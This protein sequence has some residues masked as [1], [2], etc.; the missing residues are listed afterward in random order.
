MKAVVPGTFF[1]DEAGRRLYVGTDPSG[2]QVEASTL[3]QGL[4]IQGTGTVV[5]GIGARRY[6]NTFWMGGAISA[7][8]DNIVLENVVSSQ[9]ATIGVNG[10]GKKMR[11]NRITISESGALGLALNKADYL[12]LSNSSIQANNHEL[13]KIAPV[14]GGAKITT[15]KGVTVSGS[16][17]AQNKTAGLWFDEAAYDMTIVGNTFSDN[18]GSGLELEWSSKA[19][20]ANNYF[21]R[22]AQAGLLIMDANTISVWNNTFSGNKT[23]S[24][25]LYQDTGRG[26]NPVIWLPVRDVSLKNNV[27]SY[28]TGSCPYL[29]YDTEEKETGKSMRATS[30]A[31]AYYRASSTSPANLVCWANSSAGLASFKTLTAFRTAT[32][33]DLRST[34]NEGTP[35]LTSTFQLTPA[36]LT[37]TASVALPI[38]DAVASVIGVAAN[39]RKLGAVTPMVN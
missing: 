13:F 26:S 29:V 34:L 23:Y 37:S 4:V 32:G 27:L 19:L 30:E 25:R 11:F 36:A 31:N 10:W 6:G 18:G 28:G 5:R 15:S 7:Q 22:N 38:P 35:I 8:V 3:Q 20:V 14:S 33:N 21:I 17:F 2:K 12:T 1:V 39:T 9:N 16:S 24:I